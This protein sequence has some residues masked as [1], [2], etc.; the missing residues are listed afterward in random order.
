MRKAGR[1]P[2]QRWA[3]G[4]LGGVWFGFC[5]VNAALRRPSPEGLLNGL[6]AFALYDRAGRR[7]R[8]PVQAVRTAPCETA[9]CIHGRL[10]VVPD[11]A[12]S[13]TGVVPSAH[14]T[15]A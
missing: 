5:S 10:P 14:W 1:P 6:P 8:V 15:A 12:A 2:V 3:M 11:S 9:E 13:V 7:Q 4:S